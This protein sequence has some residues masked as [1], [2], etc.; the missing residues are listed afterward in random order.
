MNSRTLSLVGLGALLIGGCASAPENIAA[1]SASDTRYQNLS[2][3]QIARTASQV[4]AALASASDDQRKCRIE[5]DVAVVALG[6]PISKVT[7]C[8]KAQQV[9]SLKGELQS[10]R[11]VATQK[12]CK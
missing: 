7:G 1:T 3:A 5:D 2:C 10:I 11:R 9:A 4:N 6:V 8:D 12:G